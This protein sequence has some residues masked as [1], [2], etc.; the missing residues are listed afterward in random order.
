MKFMPDHPGAD[1]SGMVQMPNVDPL[2]EM[3][4]MREAQRTYEANLGLVEQ[5]KSMVM[6]TIDILRR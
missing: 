4:D 2:I 1:A 5:S 3:M 6:Q